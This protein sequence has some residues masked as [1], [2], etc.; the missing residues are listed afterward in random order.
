MSDI[1]AAAQQGYSVP[2]QEELFA[3]DVLTQLGDQ[4]TPDATQSL[5]G[6]YG[7]EGGAGP[8]WDPGGNN[9]ADYN[10]LNTTLK[11]P[12][13]RDTPGN[14]PPVQAY[15]SWQQGVDATVATLE[16][17]KPG[18]AKIRSD[19]STP[20]SVQ[21]TYNDIDASSWGTHDLAT[22]GVTSPAGGTSGA[23]VLGSAAS[24]AGN[25]VLSTLG[26]GSTGSEIAKV[27]VLIAGVL[28]GGGLILAGAYKAI[29][30]TKPGRDV[31]DDAR[32]AAPLAAAA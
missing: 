5:I 12:H 20:A 26:L 4:I 27:G 8:Q 9:I 7:G 24:G 11:E 13:S 16:E 19:L 22:S 31:T 29:S 14:N 1:T 15:T 2:D 25:D 23:S 10:P 17:N 6:W 32:S 21:Q 3:D 18:Y 28:V 30:G